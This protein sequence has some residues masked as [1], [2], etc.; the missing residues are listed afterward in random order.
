MPTCR[1]SNKDIT[2]CSNY[3]LIRYLKCVFMY[4]QSTAVVCPD[5]QHDF[6][7]FYKAYLLLWLTAFTAALLA[8]DSTYRS[9]YWAGLSLIRPHLGFRLGHRSEPH[10]W[11]TSYCCNCCQLM[12]LVA[13]KWALMFGRVAFCLTRV[14]RYTPF[15]W[16][17][18]HHLVI[19]W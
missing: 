14:C 18:W 13:A 19:C 11:K 8:S 12:L 16:A 6:W 10:W 2:V 7:I 3:F 4:T 1:Y 15:V 17:C 9:A 5:T